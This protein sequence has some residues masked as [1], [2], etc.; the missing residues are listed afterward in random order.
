MPQPL[1]PVSVVQRQLDAYNARDIDAL[2]ATYAD[3]IEQFDFPSTVLAV[4]AAAVR[5]RQ[6]VRLQEPNLFAR[7]LGRTAMGNLVID[8]EIVT[9]NF[10][11]GIG[12]VELIAIYEVQGDRIQRAWFKF[13]E[14]RMGRPE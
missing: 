12:T 14:K 10:P 2:M 5:A 1:D 9:R 3:D 13:G 7:L 11:E 4:G 6:S 8:H